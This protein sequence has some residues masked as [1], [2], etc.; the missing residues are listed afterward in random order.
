L[1]QGHWKLGLNTQ[2]FARRRDS[3]FAVLMPCQQSGLGVSR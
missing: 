1:L 3:N 2:R